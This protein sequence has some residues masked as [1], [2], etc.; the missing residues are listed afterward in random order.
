MIPEELGVFV[1]PE[2]DLFWFTI[3]TKFVMFDTRPGNQFEWNFGLLFD[4]ET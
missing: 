1:T 2:F 3:G 4:L